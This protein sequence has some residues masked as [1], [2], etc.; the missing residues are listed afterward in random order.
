[1]REQHDIVVIGGGQAGLAMSYCLR[2]RGREHIVLERARVA[3]RW[4]SERWNSLAFQFPN[5]AL[6]L[7]GYQYSGGDPDGFA[8]YTEIARIIEAYARSIDAPVRC[9]ADVVALRQDDSSNRLLVETRDAVIEASHVVIATGPFQGAAVPPC[10]VDFPSR[11][12]QV[13]ATRYKGPEQLPP[14]AVLVVGSGASGCQIAEEL[15][16]CGRTVYFS[17]SRHRRIPRRY[18]GHDITWWAL[19]LGIMETPIDRF[20]ERRYP[21]SLVITGV[22]GG[23]DMNIRRLASDGVILLGRV[24]GVAGDTLSLGDDAEQIAAAADTAY[25]DFEAKADAY[26]LANGIGLP[27]PTR[28]AIEPTGPPIPALPMLNLKDASITSV[29]WGTGY[30]FEFDWVKLPVLDGRG[31]PVQQRGVTVVQNAYFLGLHWMHTFKS[32]VFF[33]VGDDAAYL[34]DHIAARR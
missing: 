26:A 12:F 9:G 5:W 32:G 23:H 33:G 16:Q 24:L 13:H 27:E 6:R 8:H 28:A 25:R 31:A 34:A 11:I 14:G 22:D 17:V 3:E 20:P 2:E 7:P 15:N 1:M 29:V 4:H 21:P 30:R 10:S 19:A 18:R